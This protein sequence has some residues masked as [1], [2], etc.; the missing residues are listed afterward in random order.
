MHVP[1]QHVQNWLVLARL[2]D[3]ELVGQQQRMGGAVAWQ[4]VSA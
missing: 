1:V 2:A 3:A 4:P